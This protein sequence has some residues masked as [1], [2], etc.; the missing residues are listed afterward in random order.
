MPGNRC[1]DAVPFFGSDRTDWINLQDAESEWV[2]YIKGD[3]YGLFTSPVSQ[4]EFALMKV[5][6][7]RIRKTMHFHLQVGRPYFG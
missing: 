5:R 2:F 7:S 3:G 1:T 4:R 6:I